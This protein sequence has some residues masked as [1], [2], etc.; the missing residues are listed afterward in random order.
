MKTKSKADGVEISK[1]KHLE[2]EI[3]LIKENEVNEKLCIYFQYVI[4]M[5]EA[6]KDIVNQANESFVETLDDLDTRVAKLEDGAQSSKGKSY[7]LILLKRY[8]R[9]NNLIYKTILHFRR[10]LFYVFYV[11]AFLDNYDRNAQK[12]VLQLVSKLIENDWSNLACCLKLK[13]PWFTLFKKNEE[14]M[15]E[16]FK[17]RNLNIPWHE[18]KKQ[19]KLIG[20]ND[21]IST[22]AKETTLTVGKYN[23]I[24]VLFKIT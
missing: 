23:Q 6:L 15:W 5:G 14:I 4:S 12:E 1:I 17:S 11:Y 2:Q 24:L 10:I 3:I 9:R 19:L 21:I 20:R 22:I 8:L 16:C 18:L 7:V 13:K